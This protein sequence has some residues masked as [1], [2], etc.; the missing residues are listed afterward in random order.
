[1]GRGAGAKW[2][3]RTTARNLH[4]RVTFRKT[5]YDSL[6]LFNVETLMKAALSEACAPLQPIAGPPRHLTA[7]KQR[8]AA[9]EVELGPVATLLCEYMVHGTSHPRAERLGLPPNEPLSLEQAAAVLDIRRRT[10][11]QI[12]AT[13][14]FR[15]LYAASIAD[16]RSGAHARMVHRMIA[17]AND[18]GE[19]TAADRS[20]QLKAVQAVLGEEAKGVSVNVQVNNQTNN[21]T[22]IRPG[23]VLDLGA[24]Y[25]RRDDDDGPVIEGKP[26]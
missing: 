4:T 18:P 10:A 17:I 24:M 12:F 20:I 9:G 6:F 22:A 2:A 16:V 13:M 14:P 15:R 19:G 7:Y 11:R 3:E 26:E 5:I 23:Y 1:V 25:G 21:T 8:R